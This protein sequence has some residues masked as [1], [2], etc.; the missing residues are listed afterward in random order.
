VKITFGDGIVVVSQP[1]SYPILQLRQ[2][3]DI[4][5]YNNGAVTQTVIQNNWIG[6]SAHTAALW[7]DAGCLGYGSHTTDGGLWYWA[8]DNT[9]GLALIALAQGQWANPYCGSG[10]PGGTGPFTISLDGGRTPTQITLAISVSGAFV[11]STA[12]ITSTSSVSGLTLHL[13]DLATSA[14][15]GDS[16]TDN[17]GVATW[18]TQGLASGYHQFQVTY[19]G[20][21][22]D[23]PSSSN[24]ASFL[25][26][27]GYS[28]SG[29][30]N[31][32]NGVICS[33][34]QSFASPASSGT[35]LYFDANTG[36][37]LGSCP[38]NTQGSGRLMDL[39]SFSSTTALQ[40]MF[41]PDV[42]GQT[43]AI[44]DIFLC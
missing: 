41:L 22:G 6:D 26:Q 40:I 20:D 14:T 18:S 35:F 33:R 2:G 7:N 25:K 32:Y 36:M 31:R 37:A 9:Y 12:T 3:K 42:L 39:S 11:V 44:N 43:Y 29:V 34:I 16:T 5:I 28:Q 4:S 8:C 30:Q 27:S 17:S 10:G 1:G 15:L 38:A 21:A 23:L 24:I 19:S 13:T